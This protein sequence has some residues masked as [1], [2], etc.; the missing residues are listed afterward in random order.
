MKKSTH[1]TLSLLAAAALGHAQ[2]FY[3]NTASANSQSLGGVYSPSSTGVLDALAANP[4]GLSL[5]DGHVV[6]LGAMGGFARG[7]FSNSANTNSP[8]TTPPGGIAYGAFGMRIG[9]TPFSFGVGEMPELTSVSEWR[10]VDAPGVAG[11]SY[12]LQNQKSAILA[13]RTAAGLGIYLNS[14][15]SIGVSIGAVYNSNTLDAPY[16]FQS[17]P[18]VKGLKTLLDLNTTGVGW[19]GS[20]GALVHASRRVQLNA[21]WKSQTVINSTG[22]A[23]GDLNR[24]LSALSLSVPSTTFRYDAAVR[25]MLPQSVL[26]GGEWQVDSHWTLALQGDW[27]NW[28]NA[29]HTLPV[30]LTNGTNATVNSLLN[31]T[32]L[33]D[34]VPL[35][36]KD[37]YAVRVGVSRSVSENVSIHGGYVHANNPVP[38]STLSPLT[39]AIFTNQVSTGFAYRLGHV[40]FDASYS[41]GL[42]AKASVGQ[43]GLLSGEY[44][45]SVVR[46]GIQTISIS[47]AFRF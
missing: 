46:V 28:K 12:G 44:N 31:S 15:L 18:V 26:V 14:K 21:A 30:A 43:S 5:I 47:T 17:Q 1:L 6:N 4:A 2:G 9:K 40:N 8:M 13:T 7:S 23:T 41:F 37:Q 25:N 38:S 10:Y 29:F 19:N 34:G 32:S 36:W 24:Q 16:I 35:N 39:A 45:N 20:V 42:T 33:N 27:T 3:W 11:A 22:S